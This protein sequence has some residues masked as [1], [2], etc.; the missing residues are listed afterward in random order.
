VIVVSATAIVTGITTAK[1]NRREE[2]I[3]PV[4]FIKPPKKAQ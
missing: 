3:R 4:L 2:I 1:G